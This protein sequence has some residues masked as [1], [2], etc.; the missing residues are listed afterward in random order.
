MSVAPSLRT[1]RGTVDVRF[2]PNRPTD[3]LLF[4][5][6]P[7]APTAREEGVRLE[8]GR[9]P[10]ARV[11][12]PDP[13]ILVVRVGP[14]AAGQRVHVRVPWTLRVP[15]AGFD[16]IA[17]F[18]GGLRLGSFFPILA[19]DPRRGWVTDPP[20]RSLGESSTSPTAD[21]AVHVRT[22]RGLTA[23]VSHG[24]SVRDVAVAV[25]RFRV[26]RG[27]AHAPDRV[28]VRVAVA[29]GADAD[30]A[31]FLRMAIRA[32]ERLSRRYGAYAW[33]EYTVVIPR[34][35]DAGGIEYPTLSFVGARFAPVA[36][37][38]H[39]T[40]H[41]WF[42]SLVGNDQAR[43]PWLDETL[44]TWA[45]QRIDGLMR[46]S[47]RLPAGARR[48]V[49]APMSYWARFPRAYFRGV[50]DVGAGALRSL[51]ND[52]AVDCALRAYAAR[53]AHSIAQPGDLLDELNRVIPG[54]ERRL[55]AWGIHR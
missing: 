30:P 26:A 13:T 4:R 29:R 37:V 7:N 27:I 31:A 17:R 45:Q 10:G 5:L 2:T 42:Y 35:F 11:A 6:W 50:Y 16:R 20:A 54:A 1:V 52:A 47:A 33:P 48:H 14:I 21:F 12:R 44:A 24:H 19:W 8:V 9:I 22:P 32:L 55:R 15:P 28:K 49:G 41:Q 25:G 38:D 43:D 40:A 46:P 36:V 34:D 18:P 51:R 39:E 53:R 3:R 23:F